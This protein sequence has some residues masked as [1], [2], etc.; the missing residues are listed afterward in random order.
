MQ[1]LILG[2]DK[3]RHLFYV[4][5]HGKRLKEFKTYEEAMRYYNSLEICK[6][7]GKIKPGGKDGQD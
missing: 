6:E 7:T 2:W 1:G 5:S 3:K 4:E